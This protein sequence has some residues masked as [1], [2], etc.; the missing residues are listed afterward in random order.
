[1]CGGTSSTTIG[2]SSS[3][4]L[5]P[6]VRGNLGL[7]NLLATVDGSIPACAGEPCLRLFRR[8]GNRVYPRVCGGTGPVGVY[9]HTDEGLSPRVR[10]NLVLV[11]TDPSLQG[12]I[13]ACAGE[14]PGTSPTGRRRRVYPRVCGGTSGF[15]H[16]SFSLSGLSPRVRGNHVSQQPRGD[17]PGSIPAC[18]GEPSGFLFDITR[19]RVYPRVCGGTFTASS[20]SAALQGLSPRVRGNLRV[21]IGAIEVAGSI[22]ACAGEPAARMGE[23]HRRRVYPRVCGGTPARRWLSLASPGLSPRVRGNHADDRHIC[24]RRGSIPACAGEP[25]G[26]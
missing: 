16:T 21:A 15:E 24:A 12:S 23:G 11:L 1:M 20:P 6:R 18:A 22:P 4:G 5:S 8:R 26:R 3:V 17:H 25:C 2:F 13:P 9:R 10:G 7:A 19:L 14:P